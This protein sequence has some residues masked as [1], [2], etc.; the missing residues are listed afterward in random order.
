MSY[1]FAIEKVLLASRRGERARF[2]TFG[3]SIRVLESPVRKRIG[4]VSPQVRPSA[5]Q[6]DRARGEEVEVARTATS[7]RQITAASRSRRD[8]ER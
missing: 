8:S 2:G 1:L 7:S 5:H 6:E 4:N 3:C